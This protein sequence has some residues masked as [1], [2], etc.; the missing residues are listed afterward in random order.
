MKSIRDE[1]FQNFREFMDSKGISLPDL[2]MEFYVDC[3][4]DDEPEERFESNK[5]EFN[6]I[7]KAIKESPKMFKEIKKIDKEEH[8]QSG[9]FEKIITKRTIIF[10]DQNGSKI[11][12]EPYIYKETE[13]SK[14][15]IKKR[16]PSER[17]GTVKSECRKTKVHMYYY[18]TC[19]YDI[20]G[21]EVNGSKCLVKDEWKVK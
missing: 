20:N 18:E 5:E 17:P 4:N 1:Y 13:L 6:L 16:I 11:S 8:D 14:Y 12:D 19:V 10:I 7:F 3:D 21:E 15:P 9:L 2:I